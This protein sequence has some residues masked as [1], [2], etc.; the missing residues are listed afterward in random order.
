MFGSCVRLGEVG[1]VF[2]NPLV[3]VAVAE[4]AAHGL[5]RRRVNLIGF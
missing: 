1:V 3:L 2:F 5:V 4:L